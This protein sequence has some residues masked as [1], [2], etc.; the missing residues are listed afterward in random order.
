LGTIGGTVADSVVDI[1]DG[2][3]VEFNVSDVFCWLS[4][5]VTVDGGGFTIMDGT[6]IYA[7]VV[8]FSTLKEET[9]AAGSFH[10]EAGD[11]DVV[12]SVLDVEDAVVGS[13]KTS[14][15]DDDCFVVVGLEGDP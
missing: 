14:G 5:A 2:V 10:F 12:T 3:V 7:D 1:V 9:M 8:D 6:M 11:A 4:S 15:V 13:A